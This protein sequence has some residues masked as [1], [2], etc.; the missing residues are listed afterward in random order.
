MSHLIAYSLEICFFRNDNKVVHLKMERIGYQFSLC[1][2]KVF[3]SPYDVIQYHLSN[4]GTLKDK[5]GRIC[6]LGRP[7]IREV[8]FSA[9]YICDW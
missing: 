9:R 2:E 8:P 1:N 3:D 7:V 5:S 4:H 6:H